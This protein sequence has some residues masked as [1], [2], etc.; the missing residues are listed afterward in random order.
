MLD[1][2]GPPNIAMRTTDGLGASSRRTA[3][4]PDS[5]VVA[6]KYIEDV[7]F[8]AWAAEGVRLECGLRVRRCPDA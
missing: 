4:S 8:A 7:D 3:S 2:K 5:V 1:V 6:R